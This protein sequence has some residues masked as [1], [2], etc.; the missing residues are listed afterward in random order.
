[1]PTIINGIHIKNKY[2]YAKNPRKQVT[3]T[4]NKDLYKEF[5]ILCANHDENMSKAYDVLIMDMLQ[6]EE[7]KQKFIQLLKQY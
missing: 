1:M 3:T 7:S 6:S 5:K 2:D 4:I